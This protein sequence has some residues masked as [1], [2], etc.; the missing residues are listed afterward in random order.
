MK[1]SELL[2]QLSTD[3]AGSLVYGE[4]H[5]TPDGTTVI[6]AAR[7]Q[8]GRDGSSVRA[9]PLGAMVIRGDNARWVA[10]VNADRI[11]LVGVLTGLLSA[12]IASLAVLRRP[13]WPDL[14]AI[15]APRDGAS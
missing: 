1:R 4:P 9:T 14:R 7:V 10:A 5:Q 2:D 8:A 15:G 6:T 13:P 11:A 12:V 3:S